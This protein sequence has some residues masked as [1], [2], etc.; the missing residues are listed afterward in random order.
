MNVPRILAAAAVA[1]FTAAGLGQAAGLAPASPASDWS[2]DRLDTYMITPVT[3]PTSRNRT[4]LRWYVYGTDLGH[5]FEHEGRLYMA[6]GDSF[7]PPGHPPTFGDDWRSNL[8]AWSRDRD[9]R[10]GISF[11]GMITDRP[12]HAKELIRDEDV[13]LEEQ[14]STTIPTNGISLGKRMVLHYMA[15]RAF[16]GPG[17]WSLTGSGLA[18]SDD[19]G[20]TWTLPEDATWPEGSNFGQVAFVEQGAHAY[21]FGIPGGRFGAAKLARVERD[22]LLDLERYEF[23]DGTRWAATEDDAAVVV[24]APVGELSVQW[25]S[26]YRKWLMTYL[27]DD[28]QVNAVVI[29]TADCLTGPWSEEEVIVTAEEAPQLYAPYIPPRWNNGPDVYFTLTQFG[30]YDVFWWHTSLN[31]VSPS[32]ER[33]RCVSPRS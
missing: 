6:F 29:R 33:P 21:L 15:V 26:H 3:G 25:N 14:P 32:D 5:M 10:D 1:A 31:G 27:N 8:L 13:P 9:P 24:P 12:G 20:N 17:F 18:Y 19:D 7:G 28:D 30:P 4:D 23:W 2:V 22:R 11:E 16:T